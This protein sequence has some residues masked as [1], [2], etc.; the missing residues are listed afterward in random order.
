MNQVLEE[1]QSLIR[2]AEKKGGFV[3]AS[4]VKAGVRKFRQSPPDEIR[5]VFI[6]LHQMGFGV[7][8]GSGDRLTWSVVKEEKP[9][10]E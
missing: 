3:S 5:Q 9:D 2:F 6:R 8:Q 7:I 1:Y 4:Q 10:S